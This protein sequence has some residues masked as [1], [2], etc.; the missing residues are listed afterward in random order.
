MFAKHS[1]DGKIALFIVYVDDIIITGD[2]YDQIKHLKSLLA[3]EFEVKDLGQLKYFLGMKI[4]QTKNGIS[5][6][7]WKYTLDLLQETRVLECKTTNTPIE[8][9]KRSE[10]DSVPAN[11]DRYQSLVGKLIYLTHTRLNIRFVVRMASH[12][13]ANP[14]EPDMRNVNRNLQYLKGTP[15]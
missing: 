12:Y 6:S 8:P 13:K 3:K 11:K 10:K 14:T 2:D 7:Q 15:S 1:V 4:A 9:A 5:I